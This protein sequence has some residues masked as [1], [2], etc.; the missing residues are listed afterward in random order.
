M[1]ETFLIVKSKT[2]NDEAY[3][4]SYV[5]LKKDLIYSLNEANKCLSRTREINH[6]KFKPQL[7]TTLEEYRSIYLPNI[8][9][10]HAEFDKILIGQFVK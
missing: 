5:I 6:I 1:S 10:I 7:N 2:K 8:E 4:D 3:Q 9:K